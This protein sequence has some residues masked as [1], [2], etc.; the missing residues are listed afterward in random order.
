M[1]LS[2][3]QTFNRQTAIK[4][5]ISFERPLAQNFNKDQVQTFK[6]KN[7]PGN[8]YSAKYK[9]A[10]PYFSAGTPEQW[11]YFQWCLQRAFNGQGNTNGPNQFKKTR[12]TLQ[13][14]V[15]VAFKDQVFSVVAH[16]ET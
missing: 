9:I 16:T 3:P 10:V 8:R 7:D 12:I 6:C 11:I 5:P 15:L 14:E 13:G 1:K 2:A 4:P